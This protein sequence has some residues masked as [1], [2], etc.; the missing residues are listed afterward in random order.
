MFT[1]IHLPPDTKR[2]SCLWFILMAILVTGTPQ[3]SLGETDPD[4]NSSSG[5][6]SLG[7]LGSIEFPASGSAEAQPHFLRGVA[8]LH[9]FWYE[10]AIEA[11]RRSTAIDPNFAMGYWGEAMAHNHPIWNEENMEA[12]RAALQH[13]PAETSLTERE[14]RYLQAIRTLFG[15]GDKLARDRAYAAH[16]ESLAGEYP[17]D[18]EATCFYALSLLGL[19]THFDKEPSLQEKYHVQAGALTLGVYGVNPNHPCAAHYTIHAFDDPIHA[20]LALP[21]ARRYAQIAPEAHHAQ[22]MPAH[23][24]VQ[25][26]MWTEAAASNKAGWESSRTWVKEKQLPLALQDYHSLYWLQYAY[27][28]QG[29]YNAAAALILDKQQDMAQSSSGDSS[30]VLGY[31][32]KVSRNYDQMVAAF[33]LETE[34]WGQ[35]RQPWQVK[36]IHFGNEF[37]E[38]AAYVR[39]FAESM[40]KIRNQ[41]AVFQIHPGM[42]PPV[43]EP[44]TEPTK[45]AESPTSQIWNLQLAALKHFMNGEM[46]KVTQLLD[47]A[48]ALEESLPPPSGPPDLIKP[49]HELYGEILLFLD[50]PK[51]AQ[52]QFERALLWHPNRARSVLGL[53]RAAA[54]LGHIQVTRQAYATFL[55]IWELADRDLPEL[56]EAKQFL[57]ETEKP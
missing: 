5:T 33:I 53:A 40:A 19:A 2:L 7:Q 17:E 34:R 37:P 29:R 3:A 27:L 48:T 32:R 42:A 11:F 22:H 45:S 24:F 13:I 39:E 21:Q 12:A 25:L 54:Q 43:P 8:A 14:Q 36:D 26:G 47:Q 18:L 31:D 56:R 55:N 4:M 49:T 52:H 20:I 15:E 44:S 57:Q 30:Q 23:I 28:Q 41:G 10:E 9:S 50:R 1:T 16:M 46:T 51:E 38:K 6:V 35:A